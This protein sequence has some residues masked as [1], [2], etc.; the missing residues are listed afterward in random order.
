MK[1]TGEKKIIGGIKYEVAECYDENTVI[2]HPN[3]NLYFKD[4]ALC[5]SLLCVNLY[6]GKGIYAG[7]GIY[8]V[9]G[10]L[11]SSY[12]ITSYCKWSIF[13]TQDFKVKIGCESRTVDEWNKFFTISCNETI[14]TERD[15]IEFEKIKLSYMAAKAHIPIIKYQQE[16]FKQHQNE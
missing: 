5:K 14:E 8:A 3:K 9:H 11:A 10:I 7:E 6:A 15:T 12:Q 1:L 4:D 16:K 13:V 2:S